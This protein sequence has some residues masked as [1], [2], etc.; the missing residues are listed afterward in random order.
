MAPPAVPTALTLTIEGLRQA[1]ILYPTP[2]QI[3]TYQTEVMEQLKN[4]LWKSTREAKPLMNFSYTVLVPGQ[5]RYSCP[6][7][8]ASDLSMVILTGLV[9]GTAVSATANSLVTPASVGPLDVNQTLGKDVAITAGTAAS[10]VSQVVSVVNNANGTST[11][12]VYP[13]F[14]AT[15]DGNSSFMLIDNQWEVEADHIANF[16]KRRTAGLDRPR[17]FYPMGDSGYDEFVFDVAPDANYTYVLRMRYYVNIMT[18]DLNSNLMSVLYQKF[19]EYFI[20]GVKAQALA[21]NDDD[22][23]DKAFMERDSK[24]QDLIMSQQYGTNIHTLKQ[25]VEDYQ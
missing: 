2:S 17:K 3:A 24:L 10:S 22:G 13:A 25:H 9:T 8:F 7:D 11:L 16:D 18:L 23:A 6:S 21:D 14:Q 12:T 1:R 4:D 15:P 20:Y 19:R 5:S